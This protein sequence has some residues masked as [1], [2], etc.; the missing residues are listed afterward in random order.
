MTITSEGE[1]IVKDSVDLK[2]KHVLEVVSEAGPA[3]VD[4]YKAATNDSFHY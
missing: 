3:S 1:N 4:I 2:L